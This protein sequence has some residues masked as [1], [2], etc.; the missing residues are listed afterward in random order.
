MINDRI[1]LIVITK[2]VYLFFKIYENLGNV[3]PLLNIQ[4]VNVY[5]VIS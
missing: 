5:S 1:Y 2:C 3:C 4:N